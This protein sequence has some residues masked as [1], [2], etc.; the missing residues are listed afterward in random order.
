MKKIVIIGA[1]IAGHTVAV[2]LRELDKGSDITLISEGAYPLYDKRRLSEF[3]AGGLKDKDI[4]L[5]GE[6]FYK[7]NNIKF[8]KGRKVTSVNTQR[9]MIHTKE[10]DNFS[11]DFLVIAS[12]RK[13]VVPE[14]TGARKSGVYLLSSLADYVSFTGRIV[15][16]VVCVWGS[17]EAALR[18]AQAA[19][20]RYKTEVKLIGNTKIENVILP[21]GI[22]II[23]NDLIEIIGDG[24]VQ[25]VK[26]SDGKVIAASVVL[27]LD[28]FKPNTDFLKNSGVELFE[29][30]IAVDPAMC[31]NVSGVFACGCVAAAKGTAGNGKSWEEVVVE[32]SAL[33]EYLAK[34]INADTPSLV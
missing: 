32:S 29:G 11:F 23:N 30:L 5:A 15:S 16:G 27:C 26:F 1:S 4:L 18:V 3:L 22:E 10:K 28:G 12:G 33:A 7:Q 31:T 25:A 20:S 19:A 2:K 34:A 21:A 9:R 17:N 14:I 8:I 6:D 24:E 13:P